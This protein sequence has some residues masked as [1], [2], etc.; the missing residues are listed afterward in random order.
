MLVAL[1]AAANPSPGEDH[2]V[3]D[4]YVHSLSLMERLENC[5]REFLERLAVVLLHDA[6]H[7]TRGNF[8]K[9]GAAMDR[10]SPA[11]SW[12]RGERGL[13]SGGCPRLRAFPHARLARPR[14]ARPPLNSTPPHSATP[15][16]SAPAS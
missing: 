7:A 5:L 15:P 9:L 16:T 11:P 1:V 14:T 12:V 10:A 3:L 6:G 13:V 4:V 8:R 2:V